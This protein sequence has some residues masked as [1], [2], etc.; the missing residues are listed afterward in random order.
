[1]WVYNKQLF[2]RSF[3]LGRIYSGRLKKED[4]ITTF[5]LTYAKCEVGHLYF[6]SMG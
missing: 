4:I 6:V 1:M 5:S 2:K 3:Y